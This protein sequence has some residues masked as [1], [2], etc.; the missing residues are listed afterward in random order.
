MKAD[1]R[2]TMILLFALLAG[3]LIQRLQQPLH[4]HLP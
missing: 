3:V 1:N 2:A 4:P